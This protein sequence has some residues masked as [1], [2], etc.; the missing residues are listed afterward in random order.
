MRDDLQRPRYERKRQK[1]ETN[2]VEELLEV[3]TLEL[4]LDDLPEPVHWR[5]EGDV[6]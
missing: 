4:V 2:L 5:S 1:K 3:G 6:G